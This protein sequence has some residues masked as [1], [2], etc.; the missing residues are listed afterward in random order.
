MTNVIIQ[1]TIDTAFGI[2]DKYDI[3]NADT[4]NEIHMSINHS[5]LN[6]IIEVNDYKVTGGEKYL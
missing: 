6:G 1:P 3:V 2:D 4:L 5:D